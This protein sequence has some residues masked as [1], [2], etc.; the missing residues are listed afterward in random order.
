LCLARCASDAE[1]RR[2]DGYVCDP[3]W[4]ACLVPG[5]AALALRSCPA[6]GPARDPAFTAAARWPAGETSN[7]E[8]APGPSAVLD[9]HG[10][11]VVASADRGV[12]IALASGALA[13]FDGPSSTPRLARDRAGKIFAVWRALEEGR[14]QIVFTALHE[15]GP[16]WAKPRTVS[17]PVDCAGDAPAR[18]CVAD[19]A[20]VAGGDRLYTLYAAGGGVRVRASRDRGAT[21][22][23]AVTALAGG[24]ADAAATAD[25]H[26]AVVALAGGP[27]G[28]Y[29]SA[30]QAI[31]IAL[32][33]DGGATFAPAITVSARDELLPTFFAAPS[34]AVDERRRWLYVAY[35]RGGRDGIWDVVLAAT[36]DNGKTWSRARISDGC[37][38][39]MVPALAVDPLTGTVHLAYFDT[40]GTPGRFAHAACTP[41]ATS[42]AARGAIGD[43]FPLSTGR[44]DAA[45]IGDRESLVVDEPHRTL[46]ALWSQPVAG[47]ARIFHASAKLK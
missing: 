29:G 12:T 33:A 11:P 32:S 44:L 5:V 43:P 13:R 35:V 45:W 42:C 16:Q 40:A 3:A 4:H 41:G 20:I 9:E 24:Y 38:I 25:G 36:H 6:A 28:G 1:C 21:W 27:L 46:H 37:A 14:A 18:D 8:P 17:D 23:H 10:V 30:Q 15:T 19:P 22:S 7:T 2:D 26:V 39:H 34:I 31:R 47:I